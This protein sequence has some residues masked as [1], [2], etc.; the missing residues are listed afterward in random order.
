MN[1]FICRR[2]YQRS[3]RKLDLAQRRGSNKDKVNDPVVSHYDKKTEYALPKI[4]I[5]AT[6]KKRTQ[7]GY[8]NEFE[9]KQVET[10]I[11]IIIFKQQLFAS[12]KVQHV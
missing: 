7:F 1:N 9:A 4:R 5:D 11:G 6:S 12:F 10:K 8:T 3:M 2:N